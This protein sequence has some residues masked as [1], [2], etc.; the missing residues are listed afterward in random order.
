MVF[1]LLDN[2]SEIKE[3]KLEKFKQEGFIVVDL[4]GTEID[5]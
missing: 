2:P 1:K 5:E 4:G 3:Q